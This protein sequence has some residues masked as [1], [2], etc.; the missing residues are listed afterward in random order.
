[1]HAALLP[2]VALTGPGAAGRDGPACGGCQPAAHHREV[3]SSAVACP[4]TLRAHART[5]SLTHTF[6]Q[7]SL[8]HTCCDSRMRP[9]THKHTQQTN[10]QTQVFALP[11]HPG[12]LCGGPGGAAVGAGR[13]A[14]LRP[15]AR[16]CARVCMWALG[17]P[18]SRLCLHDYQHCVHVLATRRRLSTVAHTTTH[19]HHPATHSH[20]ARLAFKVPALAASA[21]DELQAHIDLLVQ[22][23]GSSQPAKA[24]AA[25]ACRPGCLLHVRQ[26]AL[27]SMVC[28][29]S[30][31]LLAAARPM[32]RHC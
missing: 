21:N 16:R 32:R 28:R 22:V 6:P 18:R 23:R 24:S 17:R 20:A 5:H 11:S 13:A 4:P 3:R 2:C 26:T 19:H 15:A 31:C 14:G 9:H 27:H 25:C 12:A 1:M 10:T 29:N 7:L 8:L 30:V